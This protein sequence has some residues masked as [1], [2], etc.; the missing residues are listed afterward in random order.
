MSLRPARRTP[1][2][3]PALECGDISRGDSM[4]DNDKARI[5]GGTL[6]A[7]VC[8]FIIVLALFARGP[9]SGNHVLSNDGPSGTPG[10][11]VINEAPPPAPSPSEP[12]TGPPP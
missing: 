7:I 3:M 11:T 2:K 1:K 9:C 8:D 12:T 10:C 5:G 6:A 4:S